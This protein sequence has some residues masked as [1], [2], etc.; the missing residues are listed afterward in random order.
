MYLCSNCHYIII[1]GQAHT[2]PPIIP[3]AA[4]GLPTRQNK[5]GRC[6]TCI[7]L[8][9]NPSESEIRASHVACTA[10][11]KVLDQERLEVPEVF[12][13]AFKDERKW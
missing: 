11:S 13:R 4:C 1:N 9:V 7:L 6:L 5:P 2:C 10:E 3:C 12:Y 8:G